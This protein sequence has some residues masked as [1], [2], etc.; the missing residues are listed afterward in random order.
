MNLNFLYNF[1]KVADCGTISTAAQELNI[2]PSALSTQIR[3]LEEE[4]KSILFYRLSRKMELTETGLLVYQY[5]KKMLE[6]YNI[7][8]L[9]VQ[10]VNTGESGVLRL[11]LTLL[12][13]DSNFSNVLINFSNLYPNIHFNIYEGNSPDIIKSIQSNIVDIGFIRTNTYVPSD[14]QLLMEKEQRICVYCSKENPWIN[15]DTEKVDIKQLSG[16]PLVLS[17]G[18]LN[19]ITIIFSKSDLKENIFSIS[20]SRSMTLMWA[21]ANKAIG[22]ISTDE[23]ETQDDNSI[24]CR[25]LY[26][27][28]IEIDKQLNSKRILITK[29]DFPLST[30]AQRFVDHV[31]SNVF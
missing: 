13:P 22:V 29:K 15:A 1:V 25:P 24:F 19:Q 8:L 18:L 26:S 23:K 17:R 30:I 31:K 5:A 3:L 16:T 4:Y 2:V 11:G 21:K 14:I 9:E 28:N 27:E 12:M 10:N 6:T 20:S 7:S